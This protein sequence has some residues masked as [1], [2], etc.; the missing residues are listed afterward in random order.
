MRDLT[1]EE[2]AEKDCQS[3]RCAFERRDNPYCMVI[4]PVMPEPVMDNQVLIWRKNVCGV[5]LYRR[6]L[7]IRGKW[8]AMDYREDRHVFDGR[9]YE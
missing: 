2:W 7:A 5:W 8:V 9:K 4:P 1:P 3:Y 6:Y